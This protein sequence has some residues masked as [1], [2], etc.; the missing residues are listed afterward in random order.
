MAFL[1]SLRHFYVL[2][3]QHC[4]LKGMEVIHLKFNHPH[5]YLSAMVSNLCKR[6]TRILFHS[7]P[8]YLCKQHGFQLHIVKA[9]HCCLNCSPSAAK[10]FHSESVNDFFLVKLG[11][12][13]IIWCCS[14]LYLM[15]CLLSGH[16]ITL[17]CCGQVIPNL[18]KSLY[19]T[20]IHQERC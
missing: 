17:S 7:F 2:Q 10:A 9:Q 8:L 19:K 4:L 13:C 14:H 3:I 20:K 15:V 5:I 1:A 11:I 6:L 18:I 16:V 12:R